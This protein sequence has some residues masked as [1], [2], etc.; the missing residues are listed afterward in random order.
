MAPININRL[1]TL[2]LPHG[3]IY[4]ILGLIIVCLTILTIVYASLWH[5]TK[6][7]SYTFTVANGIIGYP[8][9]LPNDGRYVQWNFLQMNDVY[10]L[11]PQDNGRKGGLA[12]VAYIRQLLK[13][14]NPNTYTILAGDLLSPSA[15]SLSK[16]NGTTLNGKQM[17]AT[18]NTLGLDF[19]TFGNHEFDLS[20]I[21]LLTRMNESTFTW[22]STNIFRQDNN[23]TFGS[24][25]SHKIIT[26]DTVRI[27]FIGLTLDGT[28]SYVRIIN[29]SSLVNYV[30]TF[31]KLFPNETYDVLVAITH[32][33]MTID[34]ELVSNIPQIDL[35][36]GGH[37]HENYYYLRGTKYIP[38]YKADPNAFTVYIHR[39]AYN[40]DTKRL[41]IY[42]NLARVTSEIPDEENTAKVANYWFN[43]GIQG[44]QALGYE[45]NAILSCLPNSIELDGRFQSV[46]SYTTF[47]T[48]AICESMLQLTVANA[49]TIG[50]INGGTVR[51]DDILRETITQYD[52]LRTLPY[53]NIVVV[54]SVPG[55]LLAQVLTTGISLK[56]DGMFIAYTRIET[57]D[58]GKT[59]LF[60]G[61]DISKS[62]IYYNVAT[63]VYVRDYTQLN[64]SN[65]TTLYNTN[66]TQTRSLMEYLKFKYP[67]C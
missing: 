44:F 53:G 11:L 16:V 67:P 34:I 36:I 22:I 26:I 61:T 25:I 63:T 46:L 14:E 48:A 19:I 21:N 3:L 5:N 10:E 64:N 35:I 32:L 62:N 55:Q 24:S 23:Q 15:L 28:G 9:R 37:E 49:T 4:T 65:V 58:D 8:I 57:L 59:W 41:R 17:I 27:L 40:L 60:N 33:D 43:L 39:C 29:Q 54:L 1:K 50:I 2:F 51:I 42:S 38:I 30:Q 47:L 18:M 56:G 6:T 12:R 7:S 20:E 31:L 13:Q 45:P 66:V 52:I